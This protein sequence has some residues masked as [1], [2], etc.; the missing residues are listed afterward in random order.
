MGTGYP[1]DTKPL[2]DE[3]SFGPR[4][5]APAGAGHGFYSGLKVFLQDGKSDEQW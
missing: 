1:L 5:R 4:F 3:N 2:F